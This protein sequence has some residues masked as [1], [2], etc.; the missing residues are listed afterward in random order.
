M[1]DCMSMTRDKAN[2]LLKTNNLYKKAGH[3]KKNT[4]KINKKQCIKF[5]SNNNK[6]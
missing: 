3:L 6:L 2:N 5:K 4:K 1:Q